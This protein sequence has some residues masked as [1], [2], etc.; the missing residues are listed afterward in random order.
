MSCDCYENTYQQTETDTSSLEEEDS[1]E[2]PLKDAQFTIKNQKG[3]KQPLRRPPRKRINID[4]SSSE[5]SPSK[6]SSNPKAQ[7]STK[8]RDGESPFKEMTNKCK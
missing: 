5:P 8:Y 2:C 6:K 3:S 7:S 1:I 4:Q